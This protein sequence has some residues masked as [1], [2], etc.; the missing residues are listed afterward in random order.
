M[1]RKAIRKKILAD[2][3]QFCPIPDTL[4]YEV[5]LEGFGSVI[6]VVKGQKVVVFYKRRISGLSGKNN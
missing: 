6:M 1:Q 4:L 5:K 3:E 2:T